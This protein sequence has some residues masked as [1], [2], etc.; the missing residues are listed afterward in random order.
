MK[1]DIGV[2][3]HQPVLGGSIRVQ[4]SIESEDPKE[5]LAAFEKV[6]KA[7]DDFAT[8]FPPAPKE[9]PSSAS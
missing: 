1:A 9:E 5:M 8:A 2:N 3:H 7:M 4:L 6:T